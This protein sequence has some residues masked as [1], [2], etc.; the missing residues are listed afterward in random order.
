MPME[1]KEGASDLF[2]HDFLICFIILFSVVH[3]YNRLKYTLFLFISF[4]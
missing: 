4:L 1:A 3:F 2:R